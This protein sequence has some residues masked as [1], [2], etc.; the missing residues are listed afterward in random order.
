MAKA[1]DVIDIDQTTPTPQIPD[2]A[3]GDG[4]HQELVDSAFAESGLDAAL[5]EIAGQDGEPTAADLRRA[6]GDEADGL[7]DEQLLAAYEKAKLGDE[8]ADADTAE[9]VAKALNVDYLYDAQGNKIADLAKVSINDLLTG[10]VQIGYNALG[11]EVRK[12]F[13]DLRRTASNGHY[14]ESRMTKL[15]SERQMVYDQLESLRTEHKAWE[16]DR[17]VW[18]RVLTAAT[19]GNIKPLQAVIDKFAAE[20][21]KMPESLGNEDAE[22]A[23][24]NEVGTQV[25]T[26]YIVP[27]AYKLASSYKADPTEVTQEIM[28]LVGLEPAL[29]VTPERIQEILTYELPATLEAAGYARDG[30]AAPAANGQ[31]TG[32]P[33]EATVKQLQAQVAA[34]TAASANNVTDKL[35]QKNK[36]IPA[37]GGGVTQGGGESM[38][39]INTRDDMKKYLRG[40]T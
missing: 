24:A 32:N 39:T 2:T 15:Q 16:V 11:K 1:S 14:N 30:A 8:P 31:S 10:K 7:T 22:A 13:E 29:F 5:E 19:Q 27:E 35:R 12:T 37:A 33:L 34:L 25:Y 6:V 4:S 36:R 21:G 20:M 40:E 23:R 28:R 3:A 17:K 38:P 18:D 26:N 9:E